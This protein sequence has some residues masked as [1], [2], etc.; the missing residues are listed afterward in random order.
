MDSLR[1]SVFSDVT[2]DERAA[3]CSKGEETRM[4]I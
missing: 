2:M 1:S 4:P 3:L